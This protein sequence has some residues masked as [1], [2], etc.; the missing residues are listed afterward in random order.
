MFHR[1]YDG[2]FYR[3][4]DLLREYPDHPRI[5]ID[6]N[7]YVQCDCTGRAHDQITDTSLGAR[8]GP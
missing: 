6:G 3:G 5:T 2:R 8:P 4:G 7:V 1:R